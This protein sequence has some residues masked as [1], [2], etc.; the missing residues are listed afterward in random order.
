MTKEVSDFKKTRQGRPVDK[1][2]IP[3]RLITSHQNCFFVIKQLWYMTYVMWLATCGG[4][5]PCSQNVRSRAHAVWEWGCFEG[6]GGMGVEGWGVKGRKG[7]G[8]GGRTLPLLTLQLSTAGWLKKYQKLKI[9]KKR[10]KK[11]LSNANISNTL[12]DQ[13]SPQHPEEN[14]LNCH[15][16]QKK[17]D[18][19]TD[20]ATQWLNWPSGLIQMKMLKHEPLIV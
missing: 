4:G 11:V 18:T 7:G 17:T 10:R 19:R 5:W 9:R 8:E 16:Q 3:A 2:P 13:R 15:R 6:S 14:V 20:M 1:T 12:F